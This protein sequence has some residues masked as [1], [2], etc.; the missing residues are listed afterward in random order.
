MKTR[1]GIVV[2]L[3]CSVLASAQTRDR[4]GARQSNLR[5]VNKVAEP[6]AS[7]TV[8]IVGATLIDGRG[9]SAVPDSIVIVR[10]DRIVAVGARHSVAIPQAAEVVDARGLTLLPGLIDSHFHIDGD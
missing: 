4:T 2:L 6:P 10:A 8:A 1:I 3:I 5:E 7:S 9:G